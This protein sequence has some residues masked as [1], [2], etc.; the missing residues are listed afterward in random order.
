MRTSSDAYGRK[1][2]YTT[3]SVLFVASLTALL[4][5][6]TTAS[7]QEAGGPDVNDEVGAGPHVADR[8]IV[9]YEDSAGET[10]ETT[11]ARAAD[12]QV[13]DDLERADLEIVKVPQAATAT[14]EATA[15]D[16]LQAAREQLEGQ[17]AADYDYVRA[18]FERASNDRLYDRQYNLKQTGF[19]DA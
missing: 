4:L 13:R 8:L 7:G 15:E 1:H 10:A 19:N 17:P 12:V 14:S 5:L 11:A 9:T 2:A 16:A 6:T 3:L 18:Y